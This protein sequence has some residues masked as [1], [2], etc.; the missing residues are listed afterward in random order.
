MTIQLDPQRTALRRHF[1]W[2]SGRL[3][4]LFR[5]S[6]NAVNGLG[7][8]GAENVRTRF[9]YFAAIS[10]FFATAVEADLPSLAAE[11]ALE[12][13]VGRLAEHWSVANEACIVGFPGDPSSLRAVRPDFVHPIYDEYDDENITG[14]LFVYPQM[15]RDEGIF[16]YESAVAERALV[17]QYDVATGVAFRGIRE[18]TG[19]A[20]ADG[21]RGEPVDIG[22]VAYIKT[23]APVFQTVESLVR[24]ICIRLNILQLA[25]NTHSMPL[26][27][28]NVDA[29]RDGELSRKRELTFEDIKRAA[30]GPLGLTLTPPFSGE[31]GA[32]YIERNGRGLEESIA[33]LTHLQSQL[34]ILSGVPDYVFGI[35][36]QRPQES[37][38]RVLFSAQA[39]VQSFRRLLASALSGTF[40]IEVLADLASRPFT[41]AGDRSKQTLEQL[42]AGVLTR[43]E[44]RESLGLPAQAAT[45]TVQSAP[46]DTTTEEESN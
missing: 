7:L 16:S 21:P 12:R 8:I 45:E 11:P 26:V 13:L 23:G 4:S 32:A 25:L 36:L 41:T 1:D 46:A 34:G 39:K 27:Q 42:A 31:E 14:F 43:D 22:Q 37:T 3:D 30:T 19:S 17:V 5:I 15:R 2:N 44:A 28:I 24:E 38:E 35:D 10:R 18:Y 6:G 9:N 20:V 29:I 33:W 40:G